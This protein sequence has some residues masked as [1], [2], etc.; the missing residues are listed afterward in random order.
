[1]SPFR[2]SIASMLG[3][4]CFAAVVIAS[5]R[6]ASD[7]WDAILFSTTLAL[8]LIST[9]LAVRRQDRRRAYWLG[10]AFFGS[11]YL[12]ATLVPPVESRLLTTKALARLD[13][14]RQNAPRGWVLRYIDVNGDGRQDV[15]ASNV[16]DLYRHVGNGNFEEVMTV[17]PPLQS[18]TLRQFLAQGL[19]KAGSGGSSENFVRIWHTI[20]ELMMAF[21]GAHFSRFAYSMNRRG[22]ASQSVGSGV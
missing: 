7:L 18:A 2:F 6:A 16:G 10:F 19:L 14:M 20:I 13:A 1:M 17:A 4:V 21:A 5:M 3:V 12:G 22:H 9:L 15:Y 11:T 8:L